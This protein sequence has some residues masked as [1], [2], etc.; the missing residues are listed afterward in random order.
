[1]H[2][3]RG[4]RGR[5]KSFQRVGGGPGSVVIGGEL[6]EDRSLLAADVAAALAPWSQVADTGPTAQPLSATE[7]PDATPLAGTAVPGG[8]SPDAMRH[9][10]G[11]DQIYFDGGSIV[12]DGSGQ[13]IAIVDAF[14]TPTAA[15]DLAA[16]SAY[17]GLPAVASFVQVDQNGG[18]SLTTT[19]GDWALE[20]LLDIEWAHAFAP[21]ANILLV[22]ANSANFSDLM[23][24]VDF[25]RNY[26]GVS[27]VSM[28]WGSGEWGGELG[29]DTHMTTPFGHSGVTFFAAAGN[30]GG[31]GMYPAYSPNALAVG[32]TTL[33]LDASHNIT[34]EA[35]WNDSGGGISVYEAQ[36]VWQNGVVTQTSTMRAMP[37]VA[38]DANPSTGVAVY[39]TFN[40]PVSTPWRK[41]GGTSFAT[42][43]WAALVAVANQG[44]GL[45]GLSVFDTAS[46]MTSLYAMPASNFHDITS[47]SSGGTAPQSAAP[48]FDLVTGR[49]TPKAQLVVA[50]LVGISAAPSGLALLATSDTGVSNSDGITKLNNS[51]AGTTLS[52]QV[53]GTV[54]GATITLY[55]GA[56]AIGSALANGTTTIV[57][58][59]GS[60]SLA[61]GTHAITARQTESG[62]PASDAT[63]PASITVDTVAPVAAFVPV[64][65]NPHPSAVSSASLEFNEVTSGVTLAN[66]SLSRN[67][68]ANLLTGAQFVSTLDGI[69]WSL[70]DLSGLTPSAGLYQLAFSS[71]SG[72]TDV[73]GNA[74]TSGSTSFIVAAGIAA[75]MLFYNQSSFDGASAAIGVADDG[76]I[77][78]DKSAYL[79]GTGP[80]TFD[81]ISSYARGINGIMIDIA[82]SHPNISASDFVFRVGVGN[83][84]ETWAMAPAPAAVSV[85]PAPAQGRRSGGNRL[86]RRSHRQRVAASHVA[87][88]G[89]HE[90]A[91]ARRVLFRQP[92]GRRRLGHGNRR[93]DQRQRRNRRARQ[94]QLRRRYHQRLRFRPQWKR[95]HCRRDPGA[96]TTASCSRSICRPPPGR[97][98][99]RTTCRPRQQRL[100]RRFHRFH[101]RQS[102]PPPSRP[103]PPHRRQSCRKR[104]QCV[105]GNPS[106]RKFSLPWPPNGRVGRTPPTTG[107]RRSTSRSW[108][109]CR[110]LGAARGVSSL[111]HSSLSC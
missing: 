39:D 74:A 34:N 4:D 32:G 87:R 21:G 26:T 18:T 9:A 37:D 81:N 31:P 55:D 89:Q 2:I 41:I 13:T 3:A 45:A 72:V 14:H 17:F 25:A 93:A 19:N 104:P 94:L 62:K 20:T 109:C 40:N 43:S 76:A 61:D 1:M 33:S 22:E 24:A 67:G 75:R 6:L 54:A 69:T 49:G 96:T 107:G 105:R 79:P 80:A 77:A 102:R 101:L 59:N 82:G 73:A 64:S 88:Y 99:P 12:G 100:R 103:S 65:P 44:R 27:V 16:F 38:F 78:P 108:I 95:E 53:T 83:S 48:G 7:A 85:R 5:T 51:S 50:S 58:T 42:P 110:P 57:T 30:S 56:N 90:L 35:A 47:G 98:P 111:S 8:L 36:P 71:A 28:S 84:P 23:T 70:A 10:Y 60:A 97:W 68:G 46:L 11:F 63:S 86:E 52:F 29:Y 66:L 106:T 15:N 92:A 91:C